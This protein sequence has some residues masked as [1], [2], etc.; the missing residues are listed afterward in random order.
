MDIV[1]NSLVVN[2]KTKLSDPPAEQNRLETNLPINPP[3]SPEETLAANLLNLKRHLNSAF[4]QM[5]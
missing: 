2:L 3:I 5:L 4:L 1:L